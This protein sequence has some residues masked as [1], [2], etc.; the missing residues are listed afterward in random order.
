MQTFSFDTITDFDDHI[1]K[2]IPNYDVLFSSILRI[3]DYFKD[4]AKTI[5]DLGC[6]TGK[7]FDA[8]D[9]EGQMIGVDNSQNLIPRSQ[10][11]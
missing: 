6:S 11:F 3:A 2:S 9:F 5:Y 4:P 1:L 7:L 8:L 10:V